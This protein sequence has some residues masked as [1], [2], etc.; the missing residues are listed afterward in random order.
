MVIKLHTPVLLNEV[1]E[2]V[3][4]KANETYVD[5]TFGAGGYTTA[6]LKE[7]DCNIIALD[8]DESTSKIAQDLTAIFGN[9]FQFI[10][11]DFAQIDS[12]ITNQ[13]DGF[14]FDIGVSSMQID[15]AERGFSFQKDGPLDMRMSKS[16]TS[17]AAD[18]VNTYPEKELAD[19]IY[20]FGDEKKSRHIARA[21]CQ[22]REQEEVISTA[23]LS[24]IIRSACGRYNDNIDPATRTFQALRIYVNDE[25]GQL[26]L[27]LSAAAKKL[28]LGG[29]LIVVTFHSGEDKIVKDF[30]AELT[31]KKNSINRHS[32]NALFD[33][34]LTKQS[35]KYL[36]N[37]TIIASKDELSKNPRARSAKL[38]AIERISN[39]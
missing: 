33:N 32:P 29:R 26:S 31:G 9:R 12:A 2:Y 15:Q 38:R 30:F 36:H 7:A 8:R 25:F 37:G 23:K 3:S 18:I 39:D 14:V 34:S 22:A 13:V 19:I 10:N 11:I 5:A 6:L 1:I 20:K 28:K 16:I 17:S 4:P 24:A 27:G 21:I 35:F